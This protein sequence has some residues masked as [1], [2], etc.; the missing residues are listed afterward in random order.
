MHYKMAQKDLV[1]IVNNPATGISRPIGDSGAGLVGYGGRGGDDSGSGGTGGDHGNAGIGVPEASYKSKLNSTRIG[2]GEAALATLAAGI[3]A[4]PNVLRR[5]DSRRNFLKTLGVGAGAI[6]AGTASVVGGCVSVDEGIRRYMGK[7]GGSLSELKPRLFVPWSR[8][9]NESKGIDT[10]AGLYAPQTV[11]IEGWVYSLSRESGRTGFILETDMGFFIRI[12]GQARLL[13]SV[14]D[15]LS[16]DE[17]FGFEGFEAPHTTEEHLHIGVAMPPFAELLGAEK[18]HPW[19]ASDGWKFHLVN[20]ELH[21]AN[22]F[23]DSWYKGD[24]SKQGQTLKEAEAR[25]EGI[26]RRYPDTV[27]GW[28][29][30]NSKNVRF[31][32]RKLVAYRMLRDRSIL[33]PDLRQEITEDLIW[34]ATRKLDL[35][36][37]YPNAQLKYKVA[38]YDPDKEKK[39]REL[40]NVIRQ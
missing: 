35:F 8:H 10:Q 15:R 28:Y 33:N 12:S 6:G 13:P 40:W 21:W 4:N 22:G 24:N 25:F 18:Y 16:L 32:P 36:L 23:S 2:M 3:V 31:H 38:K 11:P 17:I 19:T 29:I 39:G 27:L 5:K 1:A 14:G 34:H 37:P 30:N 20:P 9:V 7:D 26:G